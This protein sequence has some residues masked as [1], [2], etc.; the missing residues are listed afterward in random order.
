MAL[1]DHVEFSPDGDL[2]VTYTGNSSSGEKSTP[3]TGHTRT[4]FMITWTFRCQSGQFA[5]IMG[6]D[7]AVTRQVT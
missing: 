3:K 2:A 6:A 5:V 4:V 7:G 1:H